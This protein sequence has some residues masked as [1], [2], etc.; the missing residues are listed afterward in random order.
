MALYPEPEK[1]RVTFLPIA[2][3]ID[4]LNV[5]HRITKP[6][7]IAGLCDFWGVVLSCFADGMYG[8]R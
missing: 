8:D 6:R 2:R 3:C 4:V 5:T 1:Y 7:N